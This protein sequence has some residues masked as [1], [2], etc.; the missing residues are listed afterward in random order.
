MTTPA[1]ELERLTF[2]YS[3]GAAVPA[4]ENITLR[5]EAGEML[6]IIGP[7]G[8]GKSTLLKILLGVLR[9]YTG[10]VR[11]FGE[12]PER[13]RRRAV[14]AWVPQRTDAEMSFPISARQAVTMT[15]ERAMPGWRSL[16]REVRRRVDEALAR[17]GAQDYADK[18]VGA[19]SGGQWQ[20]VMIARALAAQP[21]VLALDEPLTGIDAAGQS[22]FGEMLRTLHKSLG[23]TILLVSHDLRAIATAARA[24][25][26]SS[27]GG[28]GGADRVA[29]LRRT[30]HFH[31]AP[32]GITPQ[33][34]ADVFQHDLA[35]VFGDV[36]IDAHPAAECVHEH[37]VHLTITPR[38]STPDP[39]P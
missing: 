8:G 26:A 5:V 39:K 16:S 18:A 25:G 11:V 36:H 38:P 9:G 21:R 20:R 4:I 30:L 1:I 12:S 14:I 13:A 10:V 19:L 23:L 7:N 31:A 32:R 37:P 22:Q 35:A 24:P 34:L 2:A 6:A 15:A 33:V 27:V 3:A 28:A 29:C 17:T